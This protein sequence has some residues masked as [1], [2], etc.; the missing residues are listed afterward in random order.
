MTYLFLLIPIAFLSFGVIT[1]LRPDAV[2]SFFV[3]GSEGRIGVRA[4]SRI[5][6]RVIGVSLVVLSSIVLVG[7]VDW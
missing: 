5:Y 2:I 6:A 1:V 3:E 7:A 4:P